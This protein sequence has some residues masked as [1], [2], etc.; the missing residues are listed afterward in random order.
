MSVGMSYCL[1]LE[2]LFAQEAGVYDERSGGRRPGWE[3]FGKEF[4]V[5][6]RDWAGFW[7]YFG[8]SRGALRYPASLGF[9]LDC[10]PG[11]SFAHLA[12]WRRR[13]LGGR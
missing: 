4:V 5:C 7:R 11:R 9:G 13:S 12:D 2:E 1:E 10:S 8:A 6:L 3:G